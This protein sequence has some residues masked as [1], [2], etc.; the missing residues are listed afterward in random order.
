MFE[1]TTYV[2][3]IARIPPN[4]FIPIK[5]INEKRMDLN[6]TGITLTSNITFFYLPVKGQQPLNIFHEVLLCIVLNTE[7]RFVEGLV[8]S[9]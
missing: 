2:L 8:K 9:S 3:L 6:M 5:E 1:K 7:Y 4:T